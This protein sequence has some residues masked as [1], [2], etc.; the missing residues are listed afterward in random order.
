MAAEDIGDIKNS[1]IIKINDRWI[2]YLKPRWDEKLYGPIPSLTPEYPSWKIYFPVNKMPIEN[3]ELSDELYKYIMPIIEEFEDTVPFKMHEFKLFCI[4]QH[5]YFESIQLDSNEKGEIII[6]NSDVIQGLIPSE[7][8]D[9]DLNYDLNYAW[10]KIQ[11]ELNKLNGII[12]FDAVFYI[13]TH[14]CVMTRRDCKGECLDDEG[15]YEILKP[16]EGMNATFLTATPLGVVNM[17]KMGESKIEFLNQLKKFVDDERL[18]GHLNIKK[19]QKYLRDTKSNSSLKYKTDAGY[20]DYVRKQGWNLSYR[21]LERALTPE[22]TFGVPI[23]MIYTSPDVIREMARHGIT[24][25]TDLYEFILEDLRKYRTRTFIFKSEFIEFIYRICKNPLIIDSSC[26]SIRS[27]VVDERT[28]R[29]L[30][31]RQL[32]NA[33]GGKITRH[34]NKKK[35]K[36]RTKRF[37][38]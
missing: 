29:I 14:G 18:S 19:L 13:N 28:L 24:E 7:E 20:R 27:G 15:R 33:F 23:I 38:F 22:P 12:Q 17:V 30:Q 32:D 8:D 11:E 31:R 21:Y 10:S 26:S 6:T 5:P 3:N 9:F 2:E 1:E 35:R 37:N 4:K 16:P 25:E 36:T 34:K